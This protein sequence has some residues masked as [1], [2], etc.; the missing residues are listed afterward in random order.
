VLSWNA[1]SADH[2][3]WQAYDL[4]EDRQT[5]LPGRCRA[6]DR[7]PTHG[8]LLGCIDRVPLPPVGD[9]HDVGRLVWADGTEV[10]GAPT[11]ANG[12]TLPGHYTRAMRSPDGRTVLA[13]YV[14]S[15]APHPVWPV[16]ITP[17]QAPRPAVEHDEQLT[18]T[19]TAVGWTPD[20]RA[21]IAITDDQH[22]ITAPGPPPGI[23]LADPDPGELQAL[24][25]G[26]GI[27]QTRLLTDAA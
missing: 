1:G 9:V 16:F 20:G 24:W 6:L 18:S 27:D 13:Q 21:V 10:A 4:I 3:D 17:G 23:Y 8:L 25:H 14:S 5:A 15:E 19:G 11:T 12:D 22:A 7:G 2:P 26:P